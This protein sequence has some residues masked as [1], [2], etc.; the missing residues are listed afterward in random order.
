M[1]RAKRMTLAESFGKVLREARVR[2][3]LSQEALALKADLDRTYVSLL[4]RGLRQPSLATMLTLAGA[5]GIRLTSLVG[6][7][8]D[9]VTPYAHSKVRRL[10][11]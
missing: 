10:R 9:A 11:K 1:E 6:R 7:V 4:E 3:K 2:A 5:L 8:E